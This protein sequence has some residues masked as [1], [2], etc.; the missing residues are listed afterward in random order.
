MKVSE[1]T[2]PSR[3]MVGAV[4]EVWLREQTTIKEAAGII[5][6]ESIVPAEVVFDNGWISLDVTGFVRAWM[7]GERQNNGI[8]LLP[9]PGEPTVSLVSGS[10]ESLEI[11]YLTISGTVSGRP[12][13]Y[14]PF[15]FVRIAPTHGFLHNAPEDS[16]CMANALRDMSFIDMYTLGVTYDDMN[17][18]FNESGIDSLLEYMMGLMVAYVE[19]NAEKLEVTSFRRIETFNSP[20]NKDEY[21]IALRIGAHPIG[22]FP[23]TFRN[24]DYHFWSQIDDGRWSQKFPRS[25]SEIIPGSAPDLDPADHNWQLGSWGSADAHYFYN[26]QVIYYAVTKAT[27]DFTDHI[28]G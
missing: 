27:A 13:G 4:T 24:F 23:L 17:D 3:I 21:R 18:A 15:P 20:I 2:A 22:D 8:A 9:A 12:T 10:I 28:G 26:S 5:D 19:T 25:Y 7:A 14:A 6:R 16:N 11:P 1:G